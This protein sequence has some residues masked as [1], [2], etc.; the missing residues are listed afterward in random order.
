[1]ELLEDAAV[2]VL[3][4]GPRLSVRPHAEEVVG[5]AGGFE[6]GF[7]GFLLQRRSSIPGFVD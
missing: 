3:E 4:S 2:N 6:E 7:D 1:L 5:V